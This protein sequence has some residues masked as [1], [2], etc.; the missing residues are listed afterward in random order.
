LATTPAFRNFGRER[1]GSGDANCLG[2]AAAG[3]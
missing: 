1:D 3:L 2:D